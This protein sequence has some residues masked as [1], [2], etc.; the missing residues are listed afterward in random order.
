MKRRFPCSPTFKRTC[1]RVRAGVAGEEVD[2]AKL[3]E[4]R[5]REI[6]IPLIIGG[7]EVRTG[8]FGTCVIPHRHGH[9]LAKYHKA[10]KAE[11]ERA[12]AA[13]RQAH[14]TWSRLPL[15]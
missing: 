1:P 3:A 7:E 11:V 10:G 5:S 14:A 9:V 4:M 8:K 12:I 13:A 2:Q 15:R 6:E